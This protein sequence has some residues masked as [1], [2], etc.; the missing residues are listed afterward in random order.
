MNR[1]IPFLLLTGLAF[2]LIYLQLMY[3][4]TVDD[5]DS[6][7]H[8]LY[9][10]WALTETYLLI[11]H[12]NKPVFTLFTV[13]FAQLGFY[14]MK[15]INSILF[16]AAIYYTYKLIEKEKIENAALAIVIVGFMPQYLLVSQSG[17]TEILF[18]FLLIL[19][20]YL[21]QEN[22]LILASI[23]ASFLPFSRPEGY[24]FILILGLFLLYRKQWKLL[25]LLLTGHVF[26]SIIGYLFF[27]EKLLWVFGKNPNAA[28]SQTY[29]QTGEWLHYIKGLQH[30]LGTPM[31]I[32]FWLG[33]LVFLFQI[34][35]NRKKS[36][37]QVLALTMIG[38]TIGAHTLFWYLGLF[39]SFGLLRNLLTIAPLY[40]VFIL[41]GINFI[42]VIAAKLKIKSQF[43]ILAFS[44]IIIGFTFSS[45]KYSFQFPSAFKL[46]KT[47]VLNEKLAAYIQD[48]FP[49][50]KLIYH[51]CPY[52]SVLLNE[53]VFDR[54]V[55]KNISLELVNDS[56]PSNTILI[57]D[58]WYAV[59][60]GKLDLERLMLD[61][62]LLT[63][64][65]YETYDES[66]KLRS[67]H[68]FLK[69]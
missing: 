21:I 33:V 40:G 51:Y 19:T 43:V 30:T 57:W 24:F 50:R 66:N 26:Y 11:D 54:S 42:I 46:N 61:R 38:L 60:E 69:K 62:N 65:S 22:K 1:K 32:L 48:S 52:L 12:W 14:G 31:F 34:I 59:M 9:S 17:L 27:G 15:L 68:V 56:I 36:E 18:S 13:L 4:G 6:V 39:K 20:L 35:I 29:G 64:K 67:F 8:Y 5:G 16:L 49:N 55:H 37:T 44:I 58:D 41:L 25:P 63:K 45:S 28:L 3:S 47:Q 23:S 7:S 2:L 53:N 10:K